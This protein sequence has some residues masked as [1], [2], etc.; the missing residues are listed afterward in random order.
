MASSAR[1]L[2]PSPNAARAALRRL[3]GS[4]PFKGAPQLSAFLRYVVETVLDGHAGSIKAY[5]VAIEALGRPHSFDPTADAIVRVEAGRLRHAL[6][7]Y[8]DG[9]GADDP[10]LIDLPRGSYVPEF[11]WRDNIDG[12][13][14]AARRTNGHA[15]S[16]VVKSD[17]RMRKS[18]GTAKRLMN[19]RAELSLRHAK[20]AREQDEPEVATLFEQCAEEWRRHA[21]TIDQL[22]QAVDDALSDSEAVSAPINGPLRN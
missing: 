3:T 1:D 15:A 9:D 20:Q 18:L 11:H 13:T 10:V 6:A 5:T 2:P 21:E 12:R 17:W 19:E 7:R 14:T 8:Y 4:A 22:I 16:P